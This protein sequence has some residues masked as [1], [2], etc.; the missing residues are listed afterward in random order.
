MH[1]ANDQTT[2]IRRHYNDIAPRYDNMISTADRLLIPDGRAWVGSQARGDVLE[3]AVGTGRN[4]PHYPAGAA[5]TGIDLSAE[6]IEVARKNAS[7]LGLDANLVVGDAEDLG[8]EDGS[9]DTVI[10]TLSLCTIPDHELAIR[11]VWRVL[12]PGGR[13]V[14]L[15]HV[16]SPNPFIRL[17]QRMLNPLSMRYSCDHLL[18]EPLDVLAPAGFEIEYLERSKLGIIESVIARKPA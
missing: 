8:F 16:R 5:I 7:R 15:E 11:E 14:A 17:I 12:R 13:F 3:I 2:R 18:R 1:T 6:M 10:S 9:F 4:L